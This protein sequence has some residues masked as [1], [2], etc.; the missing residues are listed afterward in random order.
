MKNIISFALFVMLLSGCNKDHE[1]T[2]KLDISH[3][4]GYVVN[5]ETNSLSV[6]DLTD[7]TV[8]HE[9][10]LG[11]A[12]HN[13]SGSGFSYPHHISINKAKTKLAI[14]VP[15]MDLSVG[16]TTGTEEMKGNIVVVDARTGEILKVLDLP[17]SN[18]N[19]IFSPDDSEIWTSQ[20]EMAGKVLVYDANTYALK[21]TISVGMMP[22]E[23]TFSYDGK[24]AF[25]SNGDDNTVSAI[26]VATKTVTKTIAVGQNPIG[27]W[28]GA[29]NRNYV[30]NEDGKSVSIIDQ[31]L[32]V[33]S[34]INLG[35]TPDYVAYIPTNQ[36]VWVTSGTENK[37]FVYQLQ[38]GTYTKT[39]EIGMNAGTHAIAFSQDYKTAY[40]TNQKSASVTVFNAETK[41]KIKDLG[42]GQK[43]NGIVLKF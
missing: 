22:A 32:N 2:P 33:V 1:T 9:I 38:S 12:G 14:G 25:V 30:D 31:N 6:I 13:M 18:H 19:A 37:I 43:P 39:N 23:V 40:I 34:T 26:N 36:E 10:K 35:F 4:A 27:A 42:V 16:H 17:K 29:D 11:E 15:N 7:N 8:V 21:N 3:P 28:T 41:T 5:G 24:T 20:M